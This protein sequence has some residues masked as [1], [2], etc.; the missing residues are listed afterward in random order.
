M[1][2]IPEGH[3]RSCK[4]LMRDDD[5][6]MRRD[7]K[8][9]CASCKKCINKMRFKRTDEWGKLREQKYQ[10]ERQKRKQIK[11]NM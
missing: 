7:G 1:T 3:C 11:W 8:G 2:L 10:E 5:Y 6:I 4:R 9:Y